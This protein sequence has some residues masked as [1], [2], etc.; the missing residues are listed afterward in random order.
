MPLTL[1]TPAQLRARLQ[2]PDLPDDVATRV[3]ADAS[4]RVRA[5]SGQV[6]DYIEDDT[7]ELTG[8]LYDVVL[9]QRPLIVD[10]AH[11]I[12]VGE[13]RYGTVWSPSLLEGYAYIRNGAVLRRVYGPWPASVRVTYT[14]GYLTAPDWLTG[15][16]LDVAV[17]F[18]VNPQGLR[19][20][21]VGGIALTYAAE[22][23]TSDVAAMVKARL[24][25]M[26]LYREAFMVRTY[27]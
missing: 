26:G 13:R 10:E 8:G 25:E 9:P 23:V 19:S 1:A 14:H 22:T 6:F 27:V 4:A 3:I 21:T 17:S 7:V 16:V 15:L 24:A 12:T 20:E 5:I 18:S 2:N 11:P